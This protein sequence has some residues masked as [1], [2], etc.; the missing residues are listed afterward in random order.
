MNSPI[1]PKL[2]KCRICHEPFPA[3]NSLQPTCGKYECQ[4]TYATAYALKKQEARAKQ[5]RKETREAKAKQKSKT[6]WAQEAQD[7]FNKF[8]RLRDGKKCISCGTTNPHIQYAAGHYRTR[9]AAPEL[10]FEPLNVHSQCN[11]HCNKFLS[12]NI[13]EYRKNLILKIGIEAVEWLEGPHEPK[14]YTID[15][16]KAIKAFYAA[17]IK[18]LEKG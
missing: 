13:L 10:K 16:L 15:D 14:H 12:G 9:K 17:Q 11:F 7:V 8:I 5:E 4:V 18:Q 6:E 2:K 3:F 1:K